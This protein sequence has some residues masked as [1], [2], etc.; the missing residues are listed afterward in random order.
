MTLLLENLHELCDT[1]QTAWSKML[2]GIFSTEI[3]AEFQSDKN[4]ILP[5]AWYMSQYGYPM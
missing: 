2:I 3:L 1:A 4:K 5:I